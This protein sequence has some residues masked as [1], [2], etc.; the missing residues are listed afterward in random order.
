MAVPQIG[1]N[2]N[3]IS[4]TALPSATR[5]AREHVAQRLNLY[6]HGHLIA[7][8]G[9]ITSELVTNAVKA[10]GTVEEKINWAKVWAKLQTIAVC[11]YSDGGYAVIEG[12]RGSER[13]QS[14]HASTTGR[15]FA[16]HSV[17]PRTTIPRR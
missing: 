2:P 4:P 9:I 8:A 6:D 16:E 17:R 1:E 10:V 14:P 7:T 11:C 3:C 5:L 13:W 12:D 15:L